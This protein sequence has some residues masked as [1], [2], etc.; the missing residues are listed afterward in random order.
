MLGETNPQSLR[1]CRLKLHVSE[2]LRQ[3][4]GV[5]FLT[6]VTN[7]V[8]SRPTWLQSPEEITHFDFVVWEIKVSKDSAPNL[9]QNG[10]APDMAHFW[11]KKGL[12]FKQKHDP[13]YW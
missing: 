7:S 13:L 11:Q 10:N 2:E 4:L 12:S 8:C 5:I 1:S 9:A 6:P 3:L